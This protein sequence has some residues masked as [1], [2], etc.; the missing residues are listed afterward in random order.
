M[1]RRRQEAP[2]RLAALA[3]GGPGPMPR[4]GTGWRDPTACSRNP[5]SLEALNAP[6]RSTGRS[7]A[8]RAGARYE[9][10]SRHE[11]AWRAARAAHAVPRTAAWR[12][13]AAAALPRAGAARSAL[14]AAVRLSTGPAQSR[15]PAV[16]ELSARPGGGPSSSLKQWPGRRPIGRTWAWRNIWQARPS[17][18]RQPHGRPPDAPARRLP[19][20]GHGPRRA[21]TLR[22]SHGAYDLARPRCDAGAARDALS[23]KR[24]QR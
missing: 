22:R 1:T 19:Q 21:G 17:R 10:L 2:R 11:T 8:A 15:G 3:G 6:G 9:A 12:S 18:R 23:A 7:R 5:A 4:S 14:D 20:P 13:E 16:W 24:P